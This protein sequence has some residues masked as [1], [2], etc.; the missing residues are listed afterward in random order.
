MFKNRLKTTGKFI[1][2]NVVAPIIILSLIIFMILNFPILINIGMWGTGIFI[3]TT[4]FIGLIFFVY[5][6]F[7]EPFKK[8][9]KNRSE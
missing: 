3:G 6:L 7:I 2:E 4:L 1:F 9:N 8:S 5:W